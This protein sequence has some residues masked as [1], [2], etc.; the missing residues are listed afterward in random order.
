MCRE[1]QKVVV[2]DYGKHVKEG[3]RKFP[4]TDDHCQLINL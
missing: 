3:V 2:M 1:L 4:I